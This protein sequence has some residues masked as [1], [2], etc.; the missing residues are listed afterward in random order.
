MF[1]NSHDLIKREQTYILKRIPVSIHSEDRDISK[2]PNSNN[3]EIYLPS[4]YENIQSI[5]LIQISFPNKLYIFSNN[6]NNTLLKFSIKDS[7]IVYNY[8]IYI[9][10]G[11]Y[12]PDELANEIMNKI[13]EISSN[14]IVSLDFLISYN[15]IKNKFYFESN[16]E[17]TLIFDETSKFINSNITNSCNLKNNIYEQYVNWG[18][19]SY[20]GFNKK[21]Y[22]SIK[23]NNANR[24]YLF[25]EKCINIFGD[26]NF[27]MEI[28]KCNSYDEIYPYTKSENLYNNNSFGGICKSAFAKIP[29]NNIIDSDYSYKT[30][31][32]S[33]SLYG[34]T[35]FEPPLEKLSKFK[36]KFRYHD[37][38]LVDFNNQPFNFTIEINTLSNEIG[39]CFTVRTPDIL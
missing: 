1:N 12:T 39:K 33:K 11:T 4:I 18:L 30:I 37:G 21:N 6:Y 14:N 7:D 8:S 2:W 15:K 36:F 16:K 26:T 20:I 9:D 22:E 38:R 25:T 24:Y 27:Y 19:G 3:F 29:I 28:D 34:F 10:E 23:K 13:I 17:F 35:N 5:R 32:G 31:I